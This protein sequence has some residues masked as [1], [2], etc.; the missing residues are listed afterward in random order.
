VDISAENNVFKKLTNPV[1]TVTL[2]DIGGRSEF[3]FDPFYIS[4]QSG[5]HTLDLRE[6][7]E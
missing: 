7:S 6:L 3:D 2:K 4:T 1:K 5:I